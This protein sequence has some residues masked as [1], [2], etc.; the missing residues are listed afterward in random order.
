MTSLV[1]M[2]YCFSLKPIEKNVDPNTELLSVAPKFLHF[3]DF[4][5]FMIAD[6]TEMVLGANGKAKVAHT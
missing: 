6:V 2:V 1:P 5:V 4:E 3:V